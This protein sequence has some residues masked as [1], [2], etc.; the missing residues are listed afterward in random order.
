MVF[1]H[2]FRQVFEICGWRGQ[3][4]KQFKC[5]SLAEFMSALNK[6]S[7]GVKKDE[8]IGEMK[9]QKREKEKQ[10]KGQKRGQKEGKGKRQQKKR[11]GKKAKSGARKQVFWKPGTTLVC[12]SYQTRQCL[13]RVLFSSLIQPI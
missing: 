1:E 6:K 7:E 10:E 4:E 13:Q 12:S 5:G 2:F 9:Q 11:E 8:A 3:V